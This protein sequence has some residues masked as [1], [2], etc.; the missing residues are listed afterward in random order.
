[1]F[2][3]GVLKIGERVW[4]LSSASLEGITK[5]LDNVT[6]E[7]KSG[8]YSAPTQ[9]VQEDGLDVEFVLQG[10][11]DLFYICM[12]QFVDDKIWPSEF[13]KDALKLFHEKGNTYELIEMQ[14]S[15]MYDILYTKAVVIHTHQGCCIRAVSLVST[16]TTFFLFQFS[17]VKDG[18][19]RV[20]VVVTHIL[21]VGA[22]LL[23]IASVLRAMGLTWT[24]A[25]L[26]ARGWDRLHR[27]LVS[28]RRRV[29]AAQTKR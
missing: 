6:I 20:D 3:V 26:K 17:T 10:A 2:L 27:L 7:Q 4:A 18:Y 11:H 22:S 16:V 28:L 25:M 13:Q 19:N 15:L 23:E 8:T 29:I 14:L 1:M 12:G 21:L 24:C 5:F 9:L